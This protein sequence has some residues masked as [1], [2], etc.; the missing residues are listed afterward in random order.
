V[1]MLCLLY[2]GLALAIGV[3]GQ[4]TIGRL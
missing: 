3:A 2:V 1:A 4:Q